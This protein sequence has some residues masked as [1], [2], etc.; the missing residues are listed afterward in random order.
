MFEEQLEINKEISGEPLRLSPTQMLWRTSRQRGSP[1]LFSFVIGIKDQEFSILSRTFSG[2]YW[3]VG[4]YFFLFL[5]D[6]RLKTV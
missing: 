1:F 5:S 4:E 2:Y 6:F 3:V